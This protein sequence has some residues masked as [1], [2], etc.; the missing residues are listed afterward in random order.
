MS[1]STVTFGVKAKEEMKAL[2]G[3][4]LSCEDDNDIDFR[5]I[6]YDDL[7]LFRLR[8]YRVQ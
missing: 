5:E 2:W 6:Y 4:R 3:P 8:Q 1:H 7:D